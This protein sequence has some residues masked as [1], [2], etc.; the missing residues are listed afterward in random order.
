MLW[1]T[2]RIRRRCDF[3]KAITENTTLILRVIFEQN[4]ALLAARGASWLLVTILLLHST[5]ADL[6]SDL[7]GLLERY[8]GINDTLRQVVIPPLFVNEFAAECADSWTR[9]ISWILVRCSTGLLPRILARGPAAPRQLN[10]P[11]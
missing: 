4:M 5:T 2:N 3:F 11:L 10:L 7:A 9:V 6:A 8:P 1:T